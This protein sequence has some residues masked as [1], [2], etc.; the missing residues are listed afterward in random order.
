[1]KR[2]SLTSFAFLF[3]LLAAP[4]STSAQDAAA[5]PEGAGPT[6]AREAYVIDY[7]TGT[8]LMNKNGDARMPT[9]SMSKTMTI[10]MAFDAIKKGKLTLD[11]KLPVSEKAWRMQGSKMFVELGSAIAVEDLIRGI[12]IQ[13]GNDATIV[14][15]EGIA[16]TEADFADLTN[17]KAKEIGMMNT[18]FVN[19]SGW[20]DPEHYST[21]H[22]L[23]ILAMRTISDFPDFYKYYAE[24]EFT[25][26]N[27]HQMN[28]NPLIFR[29][30]GADGLKTGHAEE[31]GAGYGLIGSAAKDGRRVVLVVNGLADEKARAQ[32]SA[33]I[34][35]WALRSF[36]NVKLFSAGDVVDQAFVTMG[37]AGQVALTID[38][39]VVVTVP[40]AVKND[41]KVT[42]SYNGPLMAP[43]KKGALVGTLKIDVP[44]VGV[45][46]HP[47]YAAADV[48]KLGFFAG[49]MQKAKIMLSGH[50]SRTLDTAMTAATNATTAVTTVPDGA[51]Q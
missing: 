14:L 26:H 35:E 29:D 6:L 45:V 13:S 22:D 32:E 9:S 44:R 24:K 21:A 36:E 39:D 10:Y 20:P 28:R 50:A 27:I 18:H 5:T 3:A 4:L 7:D 37:Q 19:A 31:A 2:I 42:V 1:M 46:E 51:A 41:M 48:E 8:V 30:I 23:A 43:V 34:I 40:K 25:W 11:T 12:I 17:T 47:L 16:G 33:R 49:T 15:A 38:K